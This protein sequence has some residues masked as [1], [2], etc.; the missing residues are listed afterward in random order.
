A[1]PGLI[2]DQAGAKPLDEILV[3]VRGVKLHQ[4][5]A[6][7]GASQM[8][9]HLARDERLPGPRRAVEDDL[10]LVRK[11]FGEL[12]QERLLDQQALSEVR[13]GLRRARTWS[14]GLHTTLPEPSLSQ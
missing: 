14:L 2:R 10:P 12:F 7:L 8:P 9:G 13:E 4:F 1:E 3:G 11:E 6:V 5:H